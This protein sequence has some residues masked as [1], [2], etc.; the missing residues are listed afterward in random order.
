MSSPRNRCPVCRGETF[1]HF[2]EGTDSYFVACE[3]IDCGLIGPTGSEIGAVLMWNGLRYRAS[4]VP[5]KVGERRIKSDWIT[6]PPA[7]GEPEINLDFNQG[8]K[9]NEAK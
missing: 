3:S 9:E 6:E 1:L 8:E 4:S 5:D 7:D 2:A